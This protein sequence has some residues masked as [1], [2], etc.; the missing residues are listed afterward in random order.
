MAEAENDSR[1][2]GGVL[3]LLYQQARTG[4]L[5]VKSS[6][7]EVWL[8][9]R[10]GRVVNVE[11]PAGD[12][13]ILGE[14]LTESGEVSP[15]RMVKVL[16]LA[17]RKQTTPEAILVERRMISEDVL[18]RHV[19]LV[20]REML[21]PLLTRVGLVVTFVPGKVVVNPW[22]PAL[23]VPYLL[24]E[25]QRRARE[26]PIL[27]K[28]IPTSAAVYVKDPS[29]LNH[30]FQEGEQAGNPLFADKE[31]PDL[32][33][34]ERIV[35]YHVDGRR[36]IAQVSRIAG[37]DLFS[38]TRAMYNLERKY[39][40]RLVTMEGVE[41]PARRP[42]L[43]L[44]MRLVWTIVLAGVVAWV[45]LARPGPLKLLTG[46]RVVKTAELERAAQS[47]R[48]EHLVRAVGILYLVEEQCPTSLAP[49][50]KRGL[51]RPRDVLGFKVE[52]GDGSGYRV[53]EEVR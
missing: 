45:G 26:C 21:L 11:M 29:F 51:I 12:R 25:G 6:D 35:Y 50:A 19:A 46:E 30:L 48:L 38:A 9:C 1:T 8:Y 4:V 34:N 31:D 17:K 37:L 15:A 7:S 23:T 36:T 5:R 22:L 16:R 39:M 41:R 53:T 40:V 32:G 44:V 47:A 27:L 28:R 10:E 24:K 13:F 33:P 42:V 3:K 18:K 43:P 14:Y 49:A 52:C 2:L 20:A